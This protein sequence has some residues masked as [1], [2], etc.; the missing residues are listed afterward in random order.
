M[1]VLYSRLVTFSSGNVRGEDM[2]WGAFIDVIYMLITDSSIITIS[3]MITV[4]V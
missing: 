4:I 3:K 1:Q 2:C